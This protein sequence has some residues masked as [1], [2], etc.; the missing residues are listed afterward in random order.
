MSQD[1][2]IS[3]PFLSISSVA[4]CVGEP[5][6]ERITDKIFGETC[7]ITSLKFSDLPDIDL[8]KVWGHVH[9]RDRGEEGRI[10]IRRAEERMK[11]RGG[12]RR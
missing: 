8:S 4:F 6:P 2:L 3:C 1:G 5:A 12:E 11:G 7:K 10:R 9:E